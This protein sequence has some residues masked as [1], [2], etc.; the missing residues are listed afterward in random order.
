MPLADY[1]L[2]VG[3]NRYPGL[4]SL[5]GAENDA[6]DFHAWVTAQDGGKV[7]AAN[8]TLLVS[9]DFAPPAGAE[10]AKPAAQQIEEFFTRI[11]NAADE[12]NKAGLGLNAGARI[13]LFFS[14]HG[15]APSLD[16]CV[17]KI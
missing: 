6:H 14:G 2:V 1:A 15:F 8:A 4:T 5:E 10:D 17:P 16:L 12:N 13:W 9:S 11:D 3:I 7:A